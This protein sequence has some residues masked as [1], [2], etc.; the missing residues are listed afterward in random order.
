M[1]RLSVLSLT[2]A[3]ASPVAAQNVLATYHTDNCCLPPEY[4]FEVNVTILEDG[5]LT[6]TRCEQYE[7]EGPGC[8]TRRAKVPA[9]DL[10]AIRAAA[11]ASGLADK[12][13]MEAEA[14]DIPMGGGSTSG[15]ITI[16]ETEIA[17]PPF[18]AVADSERVMSVLTAIRAAIPAKLDRFFQ[19]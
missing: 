2:L 8:T 12:P 3:L 4:A 7:T 11:A 5:A 10:E 6:L 18:P 19:E 17:L 14:E 9:A 1:T 15:S 16:D 13:A